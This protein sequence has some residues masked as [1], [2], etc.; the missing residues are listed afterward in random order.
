[1]NLGREQGD[2]VFSEDEF[3]SRRHAQISYRNGH[4]RLADL[5]R[6]NGTFL[7]LRGPHGLVPGD[8]IRLGDELL[9]FEIG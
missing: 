9:R 5:G 2:I 1:L 7:K 3:M 4:G 6:S 8:L